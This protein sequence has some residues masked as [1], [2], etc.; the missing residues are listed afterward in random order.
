MC[1]IVGFISRTGRYR[2]DTPTMVRMRDS[3]IHRGPDDAGL[4]IFDESCVA[5][6]HRRLS[7]LDLSAAG[8]QPMSYHERYWITYNGEVYNYQEIRKE[9]ESKG[10]TFRSETDTEV[11]LAAYVEWGAG[12]LSRFNGMWAFAIW[13]AQEKILF[14]SRDRFGIKPFYYYDDGERFIFA[15]EIRAILAS[16]DVAIE[17]DRGAIAEYLKTGIVDGI[18]QTFFHDIKRLKPGRY[19]KINRTSTQQHVYWQLSSII[20]KDTFTEQ[21]IEQFRDLF[22]DSVRLRM[23]SD[24]PLGTCLSGGLDSS[25]IFSVATRLS[26]RPLNTF[27]AF[28]DEGSEYDEREFFECVADKYNAHQHIVNPKGDSLFDLLPKIFWHLE[29]PSKA[30]G[31]FPQWHVM[32]LANK[33]VT[34]LLDGQGGDEVLGG[35]DTYFP[36]RLQELVRC[37]SLLTYW[38]EKRLTQERLAQ[39]QIEVSNILRMLFPRVYALGGKLKRALKPPTLPPQLF[40]EDIAN[41]LPYRHE[42]GDK[43]KNVL[44][45]ELI[46]AVECNMLPAFLT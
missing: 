26:G 31:V 43:Q 14:C 28:F 1:G 10:Y 44:N 23:I 38:Q 11:I 32:E 5:L 8:H 40:S 18:E 21:D 33:E 29:E 12:C 22:H 24:V 2:I 39:S 19:L 16:G 35:Y 17:H 7:I 4:Q 20:P 46:N 45:K 27:S 41:Y 9:L 34:V 37:K 36:F 42:S 30:L 25:S 15:S 13:D 3:M 6:G